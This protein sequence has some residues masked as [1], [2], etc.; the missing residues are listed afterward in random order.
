MEGRND[1]K[2]GKWDNLIIQIRSKEGRRN[3]EQKKVGESGE[4]G[5]HRWELETKLVVASRLTVPLYFYLQF[6]FN[7]RTRQYDKFSIFFS[8]DC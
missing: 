7:N 6:R 8:R 3:N 4:G 5:E 1:R 2:T